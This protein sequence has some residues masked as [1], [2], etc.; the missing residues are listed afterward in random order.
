MS[1]GR[2]YSLEEV[3]INPWQTSYS[4]GDVS[5]NHFHD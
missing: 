3:T 4:I 1:Y 2:I 5:A